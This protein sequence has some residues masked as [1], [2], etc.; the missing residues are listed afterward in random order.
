MRRGKKWHVLVWRKPPPLLQICT[1]AKTAIDITSQNHG[2][3]WPPSIYSRRSSI[4]LLSRC[5]GAIGLYSECDGG[6][7][8]P[9]FGEELDGNGIFALRGARV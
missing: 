8:V 6:D 1:S 7:G 5:F 3:R 4:Y 2:S 9:E